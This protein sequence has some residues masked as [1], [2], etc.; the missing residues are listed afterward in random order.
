MLPTELTA[1]Q[2]KIPDLTSTQLESLSC[3]DNFIWKLNAHMLGYTEGKDIDDL[4]EEKLR[5]PKGEQVVFFYFRGAP[6]LKLPIAFNGEFVLRQSYKMKNGEWL[7]RDNCVLD[8]TKKMLIL[9]SLPQ[10]AT[11]DYT[12]V[13]GKVVHSSVPKK[14][15]KEHV[16]SM[17]N[18]TKGLKEINRVDKELEFRVAN[19]LPTTTKRYSLPVKSLNK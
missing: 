19:K 3:S 9:Q 6:D 1:S 16:K 17:E 2:E 18:I 11:G 14:A 5:F 7:E 13:Y 8:D 4:I 15:V 10:D 12:I